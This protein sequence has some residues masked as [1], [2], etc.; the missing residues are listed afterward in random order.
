MKRSFVLA[1]FVLFCCLA[2]AAVERKGSREIPFRYEVNVGYGTFPFADANNFS[3]MFRTYDITWL[4]NTGSLSSVYGDYSGPEYITGVFSAEFNVRFKKWFTLSSQ[5][6]FDAVLQGTYSSLTGERT[7]NTN[8][9]M[10]SVLPYAKFTYLNR[11]LVY[12]YSS[13]GLGLS[14]AL[15]HNSSLSLYPAVQVVPVGVAVGKRVYGLFELG[16]GTVYCGCK[17]GIGYRF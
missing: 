10:L 16:F 9:Y 13:I 6:N 17:A 2:A 1:A 14:M 3:D 15:E 4:G 5:M 11:P 7:G 8:S 12:M